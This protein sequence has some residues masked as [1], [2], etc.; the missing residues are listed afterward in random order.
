MERIFSGNRK[1]C[2]AGCTDGIPSDRMPSRR[3]L[4]RYPKILRRYVSVGCPSGAFLKRPWIPAASDS[5]AVCHQMHIRHHDRAV[6]CPD[7]CF[8]FICD[9]NNR[10]GSIYL[11][12]NTEKLLHRRRNLLCSSPFLHPLYNFHCFYICNSFRSLYLIRWIIFII[13]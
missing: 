9:Y 3:N 8:F 7:I 6:L 5:K 2:A 12:K 10:C 4:S 11:L 13:L 1:E